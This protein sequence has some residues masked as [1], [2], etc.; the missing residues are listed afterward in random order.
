MQMLKYMTGAAMLI[1]L[2]AC[3]KEER[4]DVEGDPEVKFFTNNG[5][6]GN[7]PQNSLSFQ[8][9]N[10]PD[11]A[12]TDF[13]NLTT[14]LPNVIKFPVFATRGVSQDVEINAV[15]DNSL[16]AAYNRQHNTE[17]E[18]LPESM[19]NPGPLTARFVKGS[20]VSN[21]SISL[22]L[23]LAGLHQLSAPAYM[24]AVKLSAVSNR[25]A[26]SLTSNESSLITYIL[27]NVE[28]RWIRSLGVESDVMGSLVADKS[29][30]VATLTPA[31]SPAGSIID[32][33][34]SSYSRFPSSPGQVDL[35]MQEVKS[36]G[37]I[38]LR[39]GSSNTTTPLQT[40]IQISTDGINYES[41]GAPARADLTYAS[42]AT[43][44]ILYRPVQ[45]R[46]LRLQLNYSTS[47]STQNRRVTELDVYIN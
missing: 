42:G 44:F 19:L 18:V 8:V 39:T 34:T 4:Y 29:N 45:A 6:L 12:G 32:N 17:Y 7:A 47:T 3:S 16:V 41:I 11:P 23:T 26:G 15:L 25:N 37:G 31:P 46:Y 36:L 24:A 1:L 27:V 14:S 40:T 28:K 10:Y 30:W 33:S 43:Y 9:I 35:D 2:A 22:P 38:R 21:D 5:A 13:L 20:T